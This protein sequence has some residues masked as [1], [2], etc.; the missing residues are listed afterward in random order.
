[1]GRFP[2]QVATATSP[3]S[4]ETAVWL[5]NQATWLV[6]PSVASQ[7]RDSVGIT[8]TSLLPEHLPLLVGKG[9]DS[10]N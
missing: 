10:C 3:S 5:R 6:H 4:S 2:E 8:P 9:D 7:L 1:M